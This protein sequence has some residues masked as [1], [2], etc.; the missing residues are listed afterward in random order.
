MPT[1]SLNAL[2]VLASTIQRDVFKDDTFHQATRFSRYRLYSRHAA[3]VGTV[4]ASVRHGR[5]TEGERIGMVAAAGQ[6]VIPDDLLAEAV[7]APGETFKV[8]LEEIAGTNTVVNM[9]VMIDEA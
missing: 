3:A 4:V 5:V 7:L 8:D 6:P 9:R 1:M 2:T